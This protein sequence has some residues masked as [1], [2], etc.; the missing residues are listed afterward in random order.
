MNGDE[1]VGARPKGSTPARLP[2]STVL[3]HGC[4]EAVPEA[5]EKMRAA[6]ARL[7]F[8]IRLDCKG[9]ASP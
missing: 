8:E 5:A 9:R 6:L 1:T 3:H 7:G 2:Q 4:Y